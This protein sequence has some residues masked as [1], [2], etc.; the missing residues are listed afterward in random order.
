MRLLPALL[1]LTAPLSAQSGGIVPPGMLWE[2]GFRAWDAGR[3][4]EATDALRSLL[5]P[6][7]ARPWID[8]VAVLTGER[9]ETVELT[10]DGG[11]PIWS[12]DGQ[13]IAYES[14]LPAVR[15]TRVVR[16]SAPTKVLLEAVGSGAALSPT[17]ALVAWIAPTTLN[18]VP[19]G[20]KE[21]ATG[22]ELPI[23]GLGEW[24]PT[25]ATF[26]TDDATLFVVVSRAS[27]G[28][29][30]DILRLTRTG[31]SFA[32]Q[33]IVAPTAGF[34]GVPV[35][36]PGGRFLAYPVPSGNPV[37]LPVGLA[38]LRAAALFA[39]VDLQ[40]NTV[41]RIEGRAATISADG[42]MIAWV[43]GRLVV[44]G[45]IAT[46]EN[47][48]MAAPVAGGG[49]MTLYKGIRRIDAPA[50]SPDGSR[51]AFQMMPVQDYELYTLDIS[52]T[53]SATPTRI[54]REIQHDVLPQ[55][56]SPTTVMA[57]RGAEASPLLSLRHRDGG[58]HAALPQQHRAHHRP[59]STSGCRRLMARRCSPWP[60]AMATP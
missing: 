5:V 35:A 41:R 36:L 25:G 55:W 50:L 29:R 46:E 17:G 48:L 20:I 26:G 14:G 2:K 51:I 6:G 44:Q 8:S 39:I 59:P 28:T 38:G 15:V 19:L 7:A 1:L 58:A 49:A 52:P 11:R 47:R 43:E 30:N 32:V 54:T 31:D 10:P 60:S 34:K 53:A 21:V 40:A 27:D 22:R 37:R 3:Y 13:T 9:F 33:G 57:V 4:I 18:R 24:L 23:T 56:L 16:R 42:S 12:A 45:D